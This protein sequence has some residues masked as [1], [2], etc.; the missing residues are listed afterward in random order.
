MFDRRIHGPWFG[1]ANL[2]LVFALAAGLVLVACGGEGETARP[3]ATVGDSS[4]DLLASFPAAEIEL[5]VARVELGSPA[6]RPH[7][8]HG[9]GRDERDEARTFAWG[10]GESSAL[11]L[12]IGRPRPLEIELH[13][14]ALDFPGAPEQEV[15][16]LLN[17]ESLGTVTLG[18]D[19]VRR[20]L[21][22][23]PA[24]QKRGRNILELGYAHH[25]RPADVLGDSDDD[26]PLAALWYS[27][28]LIGLRN[29]PWPSIVGHRMVLPA[30]SGVLYHQ[31]LAAGD[32]L[33]VDRLDPRGAGLELEIV[34]GDGTV[35]RHVFAEPPEGREL[36][37][38]IEG[39]GEGSSPTGVARLS[40]RSVAQA[41]GW[42]DWAPWG[43]GPGVE[44]HAPRIEG[45]RPAP[46]VAAVPRQGPPPR[47]D[48]IVYMIDTLRADHLGI[49]GYPRPTSPE[50]DRFAADATLFLDAQAQ[51]SWTRT[52]VVSLFTGLLPQVHGVNRRDD[53]LSAEVDTLAELLSTAGYETLGFYTNGNVDAAFGLDQ[54]FDHYQY[55]RESRE[56][57]SFHQLSDTVNEWAFE[58]LDA[59]APRG[60]REPFLLYLHA[61]DPHAPYTP[62]DDL[63][64]QFAAG[65]ERER[66]YVDEVHDISAGRREAPP[67][68]AE[69]WRDLYDGEIA[70]VDR[71]FGRLLDR[72]R[73]LDLYESTLVVLL[74]DH[75]EEF[76][77]HGGWEH[78]K[79]LYGEQLRVPLLIK[80]PEGQGAGRRVSSRANQ[81]DV[82]PTVLDYLRIAPPVLDGRSLLPEIFG[83]R[84]EGWK[85]DPSFAYLRLGERHARSVVEQGFK[86]IIDDQQ[87]RSA[88]ASQ[89]FDVGV[90]P[91]ET[92]ELGRL[93][94]IERGFLGQ[95]LE[96]LELDLKRRN[97]G[98]DPTA[99]TLDDALRERLEALGYVGN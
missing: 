52:A 35:R 27:V 54:G 36:R 49:Y 71:H 40:L 43:E 26:R 86:L 57:W 30:G 42:R 45:E 8:L 66:G 17:G 9:W 21:E 98:I 29:A 91:A 70:F 19:F 18:S 65:V 2:R 31:E 72:L 51:T 48:V 16:V 74:S 59:L 97:R 1:L 11:E 77:E 28:E 39:P 56:R 7:L 50:I 20:R 12:R 44:L 6:A 84:P 23:P 90:D 81:I 60:E 99:A 15:E 75:G 13:G 25:H 83:L 10:L 93:H 38:P 5:E 24:A 58:W 89:L 76:G 61:T 34:W 41:T 85:A 80:L 67:G 88:L 96:H 94:P 47:P 63:Y 33:V 82:L 22:V 3:D 32:T 92:R 73:A 4:R 14:R 69:A 87:Q 64:R 55:L 37:W 46:M 78:G 62:P 68:T 79:T 53:A 95:R